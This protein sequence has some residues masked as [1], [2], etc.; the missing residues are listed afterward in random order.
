MIRIEDEVFVANTVYYEAEQVQYEQYTA[1]ERTQRVPSP[2]QRGTTDLKKIF[3]QKLMNKKRSSNFILSMLPRPQG[4]NNIGYRSRQRCARPHLRDLLTFL[5]P[6]VSPLAVRA[7]DAGALTLG[8]WGGS[9]DGP[10]AHRPWR[11]TRV[12]GGQRPLEL[13]SGS[14]FAPEYPQTLLPVA[15]LFAYNR[16]EKSH[17]TIQLKFPCKILFNFATRGP[18]WFWGDRKLSFP[19]T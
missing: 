6:P 10:R 15:H 2:I 5:R 11:G 3:D 14:R 7:F 9:C 4:H 19:C 1:Q 8:L 13:G 18:E 16:R 12:A 17:R